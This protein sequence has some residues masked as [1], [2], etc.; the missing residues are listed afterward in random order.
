MLADSKKGT[1]EQAARIKEMD[2]KIDVQSKMSDLILCNV[3][4]GNVSL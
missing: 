2:N 4:G 3:K 1:E